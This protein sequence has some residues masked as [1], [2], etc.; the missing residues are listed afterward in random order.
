ML[1]YG[2][3]YKNSSNIRIE[4]LIFLCILG[5]LLRLNTITKF[6]H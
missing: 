1:E 6:G 4:N 5:L 3:V 2:D